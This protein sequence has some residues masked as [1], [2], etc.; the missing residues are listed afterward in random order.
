MV[1]RISSLN[2]KEL[3]MLINLGKVTEE[4]KGFGTAQEDPSNI[5]P[6]V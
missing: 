5:L 6:L 4:T 3:S 1:W 2:S